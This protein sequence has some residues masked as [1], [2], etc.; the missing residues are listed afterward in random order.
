MVAKKP[1]RRIYEEEEPAPTFDGAPKSIWINKAVREGPGEQRV[2]AANAPNQ[3]EKRMVQERPRV[4]RRLERENGGKSTHLPAAI[5]KTAMRNSPRGFAVAKSPRLR[6]GQGSR[7]ELLAKPIRQG[8]GEMS[9]PRAA[10]NPDGKQNR[11]RLRK[12]GAEFQQVLEGAAET[13]RRR[14][15]LDADQMMILFGTMKL[16][17]N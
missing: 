12:A 16:G 13:R 14:L 4:E 7:R 17:R 11:P 2:G 15:I 1:G 6:S 8:K 9:R 10:V 5:S 3:R